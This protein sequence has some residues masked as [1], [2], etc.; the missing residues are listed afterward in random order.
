MLEERIACRLE[1]TAC[2][3]GAKASELLQAALQK[4]RRICGRP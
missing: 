3:P 4:L 1:R 2:W